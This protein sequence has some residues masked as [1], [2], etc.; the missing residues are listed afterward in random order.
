L[1]I[2]DIELPLETTSSPS[3]KVCDMFWHSLQWES[4]AKA[5]DDSVKVL[6]VGCGSGRYGN[7]INDYLNGRLKEYI[8]IDL[9]I[10]HIFLCSSVEYKYFKSYYLDDDKIIYITH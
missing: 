3:R 9:K 6:E 4:I 1:Q 2:S 7:L 8:G 10:I 5:L